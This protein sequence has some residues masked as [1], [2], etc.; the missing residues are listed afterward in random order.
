MRSSRSA[1]RYGGKATR[2]SR[3]RW[4]CATSGHAI[5]QPKRGGSRRC[6]LP[7]SWRPCPD[8]SAIDS[9]K[10]KPLLIPMAMGLEP[11]VFHGQ[12]TPDSVGLWSFRVDGWGDPIES[13]RHGLIAKLDAG[14]GEKELSNDLLVGAA[15]FERAA[16]GVPRALRDPLL[17]AATALRTPGDPVTRTALALAPQVEELLTAIRCATS[18][19]A[20]SSATFG[21][22]GPRPASARGTRCFRVRPAAGTP[23]ASRCT[24]PSRPRPRRLGAS[25]TW[26]STSCTCPRSILSARYIARAATTPPPPLPEMWDRRGR[27]VATRVATT[28]FIP[29]WAPSTISTPSS[30]RRVTWAWRFPWTWRCNARRIIRGRANIDSGSPN[31]LTAQSP[32]RRTRPRST[33]TSIRSTSTM[34]PRVSTTRCCAWSGTGLT[35]ASSSFGSTIRTPSRLT[36]GPG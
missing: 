36:S 27:S 28:R 35:T 30:P 14:Q 7:K 26:A 24:A 23:T 9:Q 2:R 33:R 6:R 29:T 32:T 25:P 20:A 1:R 22:T 5:R 34:I 12:F 17:A 16:T 15:L 8:D 19:P 4:S 13:W 18:S 31:C 21:W 3:R 11:Y 10:V